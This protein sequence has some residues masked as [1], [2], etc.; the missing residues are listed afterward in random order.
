MTFQWPVDAP[1]LKKPI[2]ANEH[3]RNRQDGEGDRDVLPVDPDHRTTS[4]SGSR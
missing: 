1:T 3:R 2:Q 4:A